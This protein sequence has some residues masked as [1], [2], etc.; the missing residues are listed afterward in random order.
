VNLYVCLCVCYLCVCL[1][2]YLCVCIRVCVCEW[3]CVT[4][5]LFVCLCVY[6]CVW[7]CVSVCVWQITLKSWFSPMWV[8]RVSPALSFSKFFSWFI[9]SNKNCLCFMAVSFFS[10]SNKFIWV[11][12]HT[13]VFLNLGSWDRRIRSFSGSISG[14]L[15]GSGC[16]TISCCLG[17]LRSLEQVWSA[18]SGYLRS[19]CCLKNE[20]GD[21]DQ[22]DK[23]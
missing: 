19:S 1:C 18:L 4:V 3:V 2:V 17:V 11:G 10:K 6:V 13:S 5:C 21:L 8:L 14:P 20:K 23:R 9:W 12:G 15:T 22:T 16:Q 7:L